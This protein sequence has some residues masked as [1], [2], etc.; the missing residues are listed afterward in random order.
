ME[1]K[2]FK[3]WWFLTVN[4]LV[5]IL[6]GLL[7]LL[8][9]AE[10]LKTAIFYFGILIL[11]TG[12]IL[13]ITTFY[14]FK[15]NKSA[16]MV[17]IQ[18]IASIAIGLILMVF[19]KESLNLFFILI[20][21]WA[22]IIGILQLIILFFMRDRLTNGPVLL[23]NGLLTILLGIIIFMHPFQVADTIAKLVGIFSIVF[24]ITMIYLSFL[25]RKAIKASVPAK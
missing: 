9:T 13:L 10:I 12:V 8:F 1:T 2:S 4:G 21:I 16:S 11:I 23:I 24:G 3:N 17:T 19:P 15:K 20:G 18:S 22:A 7:L 25:V 14:Y 5:A 6:F